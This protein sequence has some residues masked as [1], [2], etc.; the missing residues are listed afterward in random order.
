MVMSLA[1]AMGLSFVDPAPKSLTELLTGISWVRN[2]VVQFGGEPL[3]SSKLGSE[4]VGVRQTNYEPKVDYRIRMVAESG[5]HKT[6]KPLFFDPKWLSR[7][8]DSSVPAI[9]T[10]FFFDEVDNGF[11]IERLSEISLKPKLNINSWRLSAIGDQNVWKE[12]DV[13]VLVGERRELKLAEP[14]DFEIGP[15][16]SIKPS[17]FVRVADLSQVPYQKAVPMPPS[18]KVAR[19]MRTIALVARATLSWA[20]RSLCS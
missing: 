3:E 10:S 19:L 15:R 12:Y 8:N 2:A 14:F 6:G 13:F 17:D 11:I 18:M 4:A 16:P 9:T 1:L 5:E 20:R 7:P